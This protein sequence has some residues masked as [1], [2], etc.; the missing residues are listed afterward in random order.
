MQN[1]KILNREG[2]KFRYK[3]DIEQTKCN[4]TK[5]NNNDR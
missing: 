4:T 2:N 5:E 1:I 3:D